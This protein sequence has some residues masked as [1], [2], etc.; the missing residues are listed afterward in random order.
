MTVPISFKAATIPTP[1]AQHVVVDRSLPAVQSGEVAIRITATAINPVDWKMRDYRA[2]IS[3]YPAVVGSD[4]AGEIAAV[5][6]DVV[7]FAE[8]DR[9]FFQGIIGNYDSS[10]FQQYCKM[11]AALVAKTPKNISD[12]QAAG[13]SLATVAVV[14]GFY[15]KTGSGLPAPWD[16][17]GDKVGAGKAIVVIGGSSSVGQYAIQFARLSG[18][19]KIVTNASA[20]HADHLKS[21]GATDVLDRTTATPEAFKAAL[22]GLPLAFVYDSISD[23]STQKLS[24]SIL[25]AT[26]T[27]GSHVVTV[28][29]PDEEAAKQGQEQEPKV[30]IRNILGL[31]SSPALRH[32]SEPMVKFLGGEEG[33]VAKGLY[34]PNRPLVVP[35]GLSAVEAAL[36]KNK[37]GVSGE[38]V[39]FRPQE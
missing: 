27:A 8:G 1:G 24:V 19:T 33:V 35:G 23:K 4:A 39:V 32:L 17:G 16:K 12:D 21:L 36:E 22:G 6:P 5:G 9:V 26:A 29:R 31:G 30:T 28:G 10:T 37:K 25:Q 13:I 7:G 18:F 20:K 3:V 14:T 2:F 38:K 11:P 34:V 15:D